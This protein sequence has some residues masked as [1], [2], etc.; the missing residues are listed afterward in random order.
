M[1]RNDMRASE[2]GWWRRS[3]TAEAMTSITC[4]GRVRARGRESFARIFAILRN[5]GVFTKKRL[6]T[7]T[8][9]HE[10]PPRNWP[11]MHPMG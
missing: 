2:C 3:C 6:W 7:T 4:A 8:S 10:E 1:P 9:P 11:P 5:D